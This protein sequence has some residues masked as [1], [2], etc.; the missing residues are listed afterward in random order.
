LVPELPPDIREASEDRQ[1]EW[2][3]DPKNTNIRLEPV[4]MSMPRSRK[5][6][7][8]AQ[9]LHSKLKRQITK[10]SNIKIKLR[11]K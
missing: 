11:P 4:T 6:E 2:R 9:K 8:R 3:N 7:W 5:K 10:R 1:Q